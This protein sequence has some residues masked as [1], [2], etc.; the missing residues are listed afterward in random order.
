M[1]YGA[2]GPMASL[3]HVSIYLI[4]LFFSYK[5]NKKSKNF[6]NKIKIKIIL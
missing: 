5:K 4:F 2:V 3:G 6:K 1:G